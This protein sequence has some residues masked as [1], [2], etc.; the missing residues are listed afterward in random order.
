MHP[1][2]LFLNFGHSAASNRNNH[3][4]ALSFAEH[5]APSEAWVG[6]NITSC[7]CRR[8]LMLNDVGG[9]KTRTLFKLTNTWRSDIFSVILWGAFLVEE[10]I[11]LIWHLHKKDWGECQLPSKVL[12]LHLH[13]FGSGDMPFS[14]R[15]A[16][17]PTT[18]II[19]TGNSIAS[20]LK[21][22][23]IFNSND[24]F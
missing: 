2:K 8:S 24:Q 5:R 14:V 11:E 15:T 20:A 23:W 13:R 10:C 3:V 18:P 22:I 1:G 6:T 4:A 21:T 12:R 19:C 9:V 7:H 17:F 16:C